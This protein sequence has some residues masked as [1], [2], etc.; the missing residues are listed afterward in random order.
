MKDKK[1]MFTVIL[2]EEE[3]GYS[4]QCIE[5]LGCISQ[6]ETRE[7]ALKNITE[8]IIGYLEAFP[9]ELEKIKA[10]ERIG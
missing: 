9:E 5:L 4:V 10:K 1:L 2:R 7:E 6:G 3:K 8:A